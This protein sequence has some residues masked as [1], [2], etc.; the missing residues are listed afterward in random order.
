MERIAQC[1]CGSLRA[2]TSGEPILVNMCHCT[3][4]QRRTGGVAGH[5]AAFEKA[6]V[7]IEGPRKVFEREGAEGRKV[8]F[9]FCPNCGTSVYWDADMRP[10]WYLV[11][12]GTF[13]DPDFPAPAVSVFEESKHA[14]TLL[15]DHI[16]R[17]QGA[18]R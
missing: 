9:Y 13:A 17:L 1:H 7:R 6:L 14:W 12:V 18:N 15:P 3:D 11:A 5:G 2:M 16:M 10:D 4:C 8:R